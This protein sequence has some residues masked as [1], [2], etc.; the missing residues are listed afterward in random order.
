MRMT[1]YLPDDLAEMVKEHTDLNVSRVCQEA[2]R[3]ELAHR[4][5]L[6][7]LDKDMERVVVY[8]DDLGSEVAFVGKELYHS[9][10][11]PEETVYLTR[12]HRLAVYNADA[13]ALYQFDSF[14]DLAN[15]SVWREANPEL[16]AA[17]AAALGEKYVVELDI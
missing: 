16:V 10:R 13:Q 1:I 4:E 8:V 2:L 3:Q 11:S 7:K 9:D 14:D 6:A 12:R 17:V 15:D 5:E